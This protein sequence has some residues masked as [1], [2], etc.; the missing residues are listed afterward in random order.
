MNR[1]YWPRI[2]EVF[3][4]YLDDLTF[5]CNKIFLGMDTD[6]TESKKDRP[7]KDH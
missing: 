2:M 1:E 7:S 5:L 4:K 6:R 3:M